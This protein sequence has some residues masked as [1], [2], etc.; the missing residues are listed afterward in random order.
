VKL[1]E[2]TINYD[3]RRIPVREADRKPGPYPYYGAS[4]IVDHVDQY[5]FEGLHLL[6][7]EDGENLRTRQTPVAFLADGQFWVNNHAHIVTGNERADT[8]FLCY[9]L[10]VADIGGYLTGSAMPK[11]TQ[12]AMNAIEVPLPPIDTQR[13]I[14]ETLG[15]LDDKIKQNRRTG[16]KLEALARAVFKAWFVDF[17]PVKAKAAGA[18]AFPG[19][20]AE[21]FATLPDR[22]VDSELGPVPEGWAVKPI[23]DLVT[24][25]GGGTPSTKDESLWTNGTHHWATP[26]DLSS[27]QHPILLTTERQITDSG[28]AKISSGVLPIDTVLLSSRAPIGYLALAKVPTA[29]NQ[30]FVAI[31]CSGPLKPHYV[32]HWLQANMDGIKARASGTTFAEISKSAFRPMPTI[33]PPPPLVDAFEEAT[34]PMF[35]LVTQMM[36]ESSKLA[37]VRD[38]LLPRLLSGRIRIGVNNG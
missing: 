11:L 20:N 5:L 29:V 27:L 19:M 21:T 24:V 28:A 12:R 17:E 36:L 4:G 7:A 13:A 18:T 26:K 23:G 33:V 30:G 2:V 6:I 34:R 37:A 10:A 38:Y 31:S 1:S 32:L 3:G 35:D 22:F 25:R 16:R 15:S 14:A 9:A 8:R